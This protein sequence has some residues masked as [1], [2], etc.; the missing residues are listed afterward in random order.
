MKIIR[1]LHITRLSQIAISFNIECMRPVVGS[2]IYA[3]TALFPSQGQPVLKALTFESM[4][5]IPI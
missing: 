3:L 2:E 5:N 4:T 1:M